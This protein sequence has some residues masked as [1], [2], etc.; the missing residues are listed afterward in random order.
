MGNV[1]PDD[2]DKHSGNV[3]MPIPPKESDFPDVIERERILGMELEEQ[4]AQED[5]IDKEMTHLNTLTLF[6]SLRVITLIWAYLSFFFV[7]GYRVGR[8][9]TIDND[10]VVAGLV[11]LFIGLAL[12]LVSWMRHDF[13]RIRREL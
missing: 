1:T 6:S 3:W 11:F 5:Q 7:A 9:I 12:G 13:D 4:R 2:N 10:G 8:F